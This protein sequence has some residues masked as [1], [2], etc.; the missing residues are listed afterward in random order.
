MP[1]AGEYSGK[2]SLFP[3][4]WPPSWAVSEIGSLLFPAA[5][6]PT[7]C[8]APCNFSAFCSQGN[9]PTWL[10]CRG[11]F[12]PSADKKLPSAAPRCLHSWPSP[13]YSQNS[14]YWVTSLLFSV[15]YCLHPIGSACCSSFLYFAIRLRDYWWWFPKQTQTAALLATGW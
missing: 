8:G 10:I 7:L 14:C 2:V 5:F 11:P 9:T 3:S 13:G 12:D 1:E 6:G 4:L 15:A